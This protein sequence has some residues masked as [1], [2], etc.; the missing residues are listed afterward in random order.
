MTSENVAEQDAAESAAAVSAKT[1]DDQLI[2]ELVSRAQ[3]EGLQ[4]TGE[5]GLLQQLT[6]RLLES[7]LEGEITDHLGY[8]KHDPAGRNGGNSR[9]GT[10]S[11][12]VL[13]DVGPVEIVVPRDRDGSFEPKIVKKRLTGVDEMVISLAAKGLTTIEVQAHLAEVYGAEVS[14]QTISAITDKV[15]EGMAEWQSRPLDAVYPVVFIDAIHVKIRDG[16]VANRPIYV[17]LAV[18]VEGRR[19]ILGLWAG[20]GGEGAKHWLH[21]LTEIQNRGV[22]DV[23]MLVCDGLK[24]LP[25]AVETL[26][27]R[28][29]V[30]TCVV[31]PLR[32]SFR[33]A[34]RQDWDKIARLLKPV[35]TAPTEEAALERF[36]EFA[37]AW[38]RKY[39]AIVKLWENAW[40]E[41]T[42]FLRFD[43][44]IRRIVCTTNAIE[45]VNARIR[46]AVKARGHFP[47]EQAALK[48]VYMAIM[49]FDPTGKGQARWTMRWK[50]ALNAF[51]ITFD[52]RLSAARQ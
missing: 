11:K 6:K 42:P 35:Y 34:A 46:R 22:S 26:W 21:I 25:E 41:F 15:L 31:H 13:T 43:T 9:N 32:S 45:S 8:D 49:S 39:P 47:N 38:G 23:L 18:T 14:R 48:C 27:P 29:I 36:A 44:E 12:T 20:D 5:G 2:D 40:E 16:A 17:A 4:L 51:D 24:G 19:E 7:A 37:D 1:V 52:G 33:Y 3:A 50:T 28:T 30:Q 10:R